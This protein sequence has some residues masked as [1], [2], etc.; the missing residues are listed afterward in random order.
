LTDDE[1]FWKGCEGCV[2]F[3]VLQRN[4]RKMCLCTGL[5]YDPEEH[6]EYKKQNI[7]PLPLIVSKISSILTF[8]K[9]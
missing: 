3:D 9:L 5:L 8:K 7:K 1:E 4:N 2:N 6:K